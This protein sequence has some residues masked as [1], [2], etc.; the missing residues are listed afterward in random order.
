[1]WYDFLVR[2]CDLSL[3]GEGVS[4][5]MA[6]EDF[7][8]LCVAM[9]SALLLLLTIGTQLLSRSSTFPRTCQKSTRKRH[10]SGL[11]EDSVV[12]ERKKK[13]INEVKGSRQV[14]QRVSIARNSQAHHLHTPCSR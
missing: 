10:H 11:R 3:E 1:M 4:L 14:V 9:L 8:W 13:S 5:K 7:V 6:P 2:M 12:R